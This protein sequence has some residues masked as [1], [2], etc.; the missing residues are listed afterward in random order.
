MNTENLKRGRERFG[1]MGRRALLTGLVATAAA[2]TPIAR[3][4][5]ASD[6]ADD[7]EP[8]PFI[9]GRFQFTMIR[10]RRSVPS[11]RLFGI[12]G[13]SID[14]ASLRGKPI[15]LN[16]WASWCPACRM[17]LPMLDR[18]LQR[19]GRHGLQI[20]AVSED[21]ADR[22]V[23]ERFTRE[24]GITHLPVYQDPSGYVAYSNAENPHNAPFALYGMPM[25]YAIAASGWVVGY[26]AGA[27]DWTTADG[28]RFISFLY[29]A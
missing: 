29:G 25:T 17:E 10:P 1:P 16:F 23:V 12:D 13:R 11:L 28:Q 3:I 18:M 4:R 8:P 7:A 15:L 19:Q 21:R 9:S 2:A 24:I 26:I 5:A 20:I 22:Q 6:F 14:L 27:A